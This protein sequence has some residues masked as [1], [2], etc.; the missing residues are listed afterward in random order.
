M[1]LRIKH[2]SAAAQ[3]LTSQDS[4]ILTNDH[5]FAKRVTLVACMINSRNGSS[6][7]VNKHSRIVAI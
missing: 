1:S 5:L 2:E 7:T 3:W 4:A 6:R